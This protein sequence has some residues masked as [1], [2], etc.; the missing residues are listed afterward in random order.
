MS[1]W[2]ALLVCYVSYAGV[3]IEYLAAQ[4][5]ICLKVVDTDS[6]GISLL[7]WEY[8]YLV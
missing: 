4:L 8:D 3:W 5:I 6:S 2:F 1:G 7:V